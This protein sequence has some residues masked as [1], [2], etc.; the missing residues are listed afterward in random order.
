MTIK[1]IETVVNGTDFKDL[2]AFK[3][4]VYDEFER[5]K[6][7]ILKIDEDFEIK[8]DDFN[9][10]FEIR[11]DYLDKNDIKKRWLY[12]VRLHGC[13]YNKSITIGNYI[14]ICTHKLTPDF[15]TSHTE[16]YGSIST[17]EATNDQVYRTYNFVIDYE[18]NISTVDLKH[19]R[20]ND[21]K[22]AKDK[23]VEFKPTKINYEYHGTNIHDLVND[24]IIRLMKL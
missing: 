9:P 8:L 2:A 18:N 12:V 7:N 16:G 11:Y 21:A 20:L 1:F 22:K 15:K 24:A 23:G 10:K 5:N 4:H 17:K 6:G 3:S 13:S 19:F 14:C